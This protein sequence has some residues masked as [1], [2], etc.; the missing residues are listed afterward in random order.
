MTQE[1]IFREHRLQ[2][3]KLRLQQAIINNRSVYLS[4]WGLQHPWLTKEETDAI[5]N[6]LVVTG[7]CVLVKGRNGGD[8]L[9]THGDEARREQAASNA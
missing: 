6:E 7:F 2:G 1:Q 5:V 3:M 9:M 8:K 4:S